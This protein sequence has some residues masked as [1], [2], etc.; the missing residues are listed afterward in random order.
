MGGACSRYEYRRGSHRV[1]VG[2]PSGFTFKKDLGADGR[3]I[4]KW[5][6]KKC[7]GRHG[8]K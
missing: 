6:L 1:L 2:K 4:L 7:D 3:I 8:L 5:V